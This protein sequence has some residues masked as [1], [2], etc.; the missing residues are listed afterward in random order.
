MILASFP[1]LEK[2]D[3]RSTSMGASGEDIQLSPAARKL[4]PYQVECKN[5]RDSSVHTMFHQA[6][7]HGNREPVLFVKRDRDI[8][9]A[10]VTAEHFMELIT[11]NNENKPSNPD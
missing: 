11:K 7:G 1:Q 2:D 4:F 9:L 8:A 6:I 5:K 10:V 3:V